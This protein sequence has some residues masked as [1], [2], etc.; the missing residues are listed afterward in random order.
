MV[1]S[2]ALS[3]GVSLV[4]GSLVLAACNSM[5][6]PPDAGNT[7]GT[8]A[9]PSGGTAVA[10]TSVTVRDFRFD[11]ACIVVSAGATVTWTNTGMPIHTVT[12]DTG[13]PE[14][15]DSGSL[16]SGGGFT[17]TFASPGTIGYH[18][19]VHQSIGMVGT[20]IVQ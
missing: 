17:R 7:G 18:C 4:L 13:A 11:P 8:V 2:R 19:A 10:T 5:T 3:V 15:F 1:F 9:C 14:S 20:I 16:G 12:S 6:S